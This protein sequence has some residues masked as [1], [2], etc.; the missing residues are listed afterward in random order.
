MAATGLVSR[1]SASICEKDWSNL[2]AVRLQQ[3]KGD[4]SNASFKV[5][6]DALMLT[7]IDFDTLYRHEVI[8]ADSV[9]CVNPQFEL[10]VDIPKKSDRKK[11]A[12]K[13]D[14]IIQQL[15]GNL[16]LGFVV[17]QNAS[18]NISTTRNE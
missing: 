12:P 3:P 11:Q 15:T 14:R 13:L 9:Y 18:F 16:Q 1:G 10:D 17:V 2:I 4:S 8:K 5:F 7:D 6:F